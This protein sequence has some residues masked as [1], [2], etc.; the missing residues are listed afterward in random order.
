MPGLKPTKEKVSGREERKR[1]KAGVSN[2]DMKRM[3]PIL[4]KRQEV[5]DARN[6][7]IGANRNREEK[8]EFGGG[9]NRWKPKTETRHVSVVLPK[10]QPEKKVGYSHANTGRE[11]ARERMRRKG[12]N[13]C[14]PWGIEN[15]A[16]ITN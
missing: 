10:W 6:L 2:N 5:A 9:E 1:W 3:D 12:N 11:V 8:K 14:V 4:Q 13:L 7:V 16:Q 15:G